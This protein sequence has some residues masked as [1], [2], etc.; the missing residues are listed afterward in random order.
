[1]LPYNLLAP[2]TPFVEPPPSIAWGRTTITPRSPGG[3]VF[4]D[5]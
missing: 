1:M 4:E 5:I 3:D 2:A